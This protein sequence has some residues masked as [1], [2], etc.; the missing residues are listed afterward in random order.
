MQW[1]LHKED[2]SVGQIFYLCFFLVSYDWVK[3]LIRNRELGT[4]MEMWKMCNFKRN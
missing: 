3:C 4:T 2:Y 1:L